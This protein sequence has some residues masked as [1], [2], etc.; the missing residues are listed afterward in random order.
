LIHP[1]WLEVQKS[2]QKW[3]P[4]VGADNKPVEWIK[5]EA[6]SCDPIA[7]ERQGVGC[8]ASACALRHGVPVSA[9]ETYN[10]IC[11]VVGRF[12]P[13]IFSKCGERAKHTEIM[14][15]VELGIRDTCDLS[16]VREGLERFFIGS[17]QKRTA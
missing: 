11:S 7:L 16:G 5:R 1:L 4:G 3:F 10:N 17:G 12:I 9:E 15:G 2:F 6:V 13:L 8:L 14:K